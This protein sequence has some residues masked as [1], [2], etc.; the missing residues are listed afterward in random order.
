MREVVFCRYGMDYLRTFPRPDDLTIG[1]FR[2]NLDYLIWQSMKKTQESD[3][4][5]LMEMSVLKAKGQQQMAK[6]IQSVADDQNK[7]TPLLP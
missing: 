3:G 1:S 4:K 7:D 5:S 6:Q 2:V